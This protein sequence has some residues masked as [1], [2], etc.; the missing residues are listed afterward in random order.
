[1]RENFRLERERERADALLSGHS[2]AFARR[3]LN[4]QDRQEFSSIL[5]GIQGFPPN[6]ASW[7]HSY[8]L[9]V[10]GWLGHVRTE[11]QTN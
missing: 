10:N 6:P 9:L 1:M 7:L 3:K 8:E 11:R 2:Q 4:G 5:T